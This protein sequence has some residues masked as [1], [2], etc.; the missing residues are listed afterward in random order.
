MAEAFFSHRKQEANPAQILFFRP[1]N[2]SGMSGTTA[3]PTSLTFM[4]SQ[5]CTMQKDNHH[6][7]MRTYLL[8]LH[9]IDALVLLT[10]N[11]YF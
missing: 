7:Y 11:R 5:F 6:K 2:P 1:G 4:Q 3:S 9:R 8:S 10:L